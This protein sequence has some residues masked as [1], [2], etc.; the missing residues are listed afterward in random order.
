MSI[1]YCLISK[2]LDVVLCEYIDSDYAGNFQQISRLLLRKIK[3]NAKFTIDYD[4]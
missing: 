1:I 3:K 2:A 4:K